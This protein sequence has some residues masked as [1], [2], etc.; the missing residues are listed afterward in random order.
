MTA[1]LRMTAKPET[2]L[3][4]CCQAFAESYAIVEVL[5]LQPDLQLLEVGAGSGWPGLYLAAIDAGLLVRDIYV[6]AAR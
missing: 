5:N 4:D 2:R 1:E 6:A 3:D